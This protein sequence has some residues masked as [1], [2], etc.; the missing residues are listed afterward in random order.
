M[1]ALD[2]FCGMGGATLGMKWAG[3]DVLGVEFD[4]K[5]VE[6]HEHVCGPGSTMR[7]DIASMRQADMERP[8]LLWA[9]P[10]CQP[11][12]QA[13]LRRGL[14]DPRGHLIFEVPRWVRVLRPR[15][16]ICEQV[17]AALPWW[18]GFAEEFEALGYHCW[19]GLVSAEQFGVPQTRVRAVLLASLDGPV[20]EPRPT[21]RKFWRNPPHVRDGDEHLPKWVSM[22]EALDGVVGAEDLVG[23]ARR[24]DLGT[25]PH[26]YRERD[27]RP[28]SEPA[29]TLTSKGRSWTVNTGLD[30]KKGEDRSKA[31]KR[32]VTTLSGTQWILEGRQSKLDGEKLT[33]ADGLAL[34][35]FPPDC[36]DGMKVT[37]TAAFKAIGN[38]VPPLLALR[39][40]EQLT[41][42]AR[43]ERDE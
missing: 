24:D 23:F 10:P 12:S 29:L 42:G 36:L 11:F 5:A 14:A 21:H 6:L 30:W 35:S 4:A 3:F 37:R 17:R 26:G 13:G 34:Q 15:F 43:E 7:A 31:Q 27:L 40:A 22:A 20:E 19:T 9:S 39:L 1:K 2:L 41:R 38:A 28:G 8:H 33:V 32:S 18:E 25:S 16:V